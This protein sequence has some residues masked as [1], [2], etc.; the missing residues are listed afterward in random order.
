MPDMVYKYTSITDNLKLSLQITYREDDGDTSTNGLAA[1][2][3][4]SVTHEEVLP[5]V[6]LPA[7]HAST[8]EQ[9]LDGIACRQGCV[10]TALLDV[11][12]R[13]RATCAGRDSTGLVGTVHC[14]CVM[15]FVRV[16]T[17]VYC[18]C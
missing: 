13:L 1:I 7:Q 6:A 9:D 2:Q 5:A 17:F 15:G 14:E 10:D 12:G 11:D 16:E 18:R 4:R 3:G 8:E